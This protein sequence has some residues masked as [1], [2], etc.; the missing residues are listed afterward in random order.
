MVVPGLTDNATKGIRR[1]K[2][3]MSAND[4]AAIFEPMVH[5][6]I[7]LILDQIR[8]LKGNVSRILLVGGFGQSSYL[9]EQIRE[10]IDDIEILQ[11]GNG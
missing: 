5:E 1:A 6:V 7:D 8:M 3:T 2:Y 9:R 4:V 10:S 11:P